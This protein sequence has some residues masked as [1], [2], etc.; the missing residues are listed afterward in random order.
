M[1]YLFNNGTDQPELLFDG[2]PPVCC[3]Y[4][5]EIVWLPNIPESYRIY[6]ELESPNNLCLNGMSYNGY[7][8]TTADFYNNGASPDASYFINNTWHGISWSE[9][10]KMI[11]YNDANGYQAY[12]DELTFRVSAY[13]DQFD[14][15]QFKTNQYYQPT[16]TAKITVNELGTRDSK[17]VASKNV[18][19]QPNTTY[20]IN[21]GDID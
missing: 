7:T 11:D 4:N 6:I 15:F 10:G 18:V 8:C 13:G 20:T 16:V 14:N 5:G 1:A 21:R 2:A 19:L 17:T 9:V 12:C 3:V